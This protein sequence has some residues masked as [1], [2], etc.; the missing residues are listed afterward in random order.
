M[1]PRRVVRSLLVLLAACGLAGCG[2][3]SQSSPHEIDRADVPFGLAGAPSATT[4]VPGNSPYSFTIF[5]VDNDQLRA[6]RRGARAA[7]T[8]VSRLRALTQG[9]TPAEA[10]AGLNTLLSPDITVQEVHVNDGVATVVLS[11]EGATQSAGNERALAIAQLV[12]TAT[13]IPGVERVRFEVEGKPTEVPRGDGTLTSKPV[14]RA[15]YRL[16]AP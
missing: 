8:P 13:A 16:A 3:G 9:P 7:P 11:G 4:T 15:D 6:V 10:D 2:V 5:L 12:Y 14:S 1:K